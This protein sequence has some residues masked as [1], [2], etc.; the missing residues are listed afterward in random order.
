MKLTAKMQA[1][2]NAQMRAEFGAYY[3][4]LA[5]AAWLSHRNFIGS[6]RWMRLQAQEESKH[7]MKFF[8]YIDDRGGEIALKAIEK[9][10]AD[11][12]SV[13]A[14]FEAA[15]EHEARV[16]A[17]IQRLYEL[18][19]GQKDYTSETMLQWFLTEQVEEEKTSTQIVETLRII[20]DSS[21]GLLM[22]DRELGRRT[23]AE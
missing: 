4:Y 5:M 7:A 12:K 22:Y 16:S 9:P 2:M 1:A 8:D 23:R 20:G 11:W 17:G 19:L 10:K 21:S 6:A 15:Q 18:A 13:L 3:L 14:V